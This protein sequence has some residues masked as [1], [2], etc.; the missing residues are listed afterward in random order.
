MTFEIQYKLKFEGARTRVV[1]HPTPTPNEK[2]PHPTPEKS[3]QSS[4]PPHP[5]GGVIYNPD[6]G[7]EI[8]VFNSTHMIKTFKTAEWYNC[9]SVDLDGIKAPEQKIS[10]VTYKV[11]VN[12]FELNQDGYDE[13]EF[14][15]DSDEKSTG[16]S[17]KN[18]EED[19]D[20]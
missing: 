3:G 2:P 18:S 12:L 1:N 9:F 10:D 5:S 20:Y 15:D 14:D 19:S 8:F 4:R 11:V 17:D 6:P 7:F 16:D 13:F